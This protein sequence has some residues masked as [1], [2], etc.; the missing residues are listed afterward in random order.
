MRRRA[1]LTGV[2]GIGLAAAGAGGKRADTA[3]A[4]RS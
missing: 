2:L 1:I 4:V 3:E